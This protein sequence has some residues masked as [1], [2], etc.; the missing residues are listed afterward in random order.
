MF[1]GEGRSKYLLVSC[2]CPRNGFQNV[3]NHSPPPRGGNSR[4]QTMD[5]KPGHDHILGRTANCG[6]PSR[7]TY[8]M[9]WRPQT[10]LAKKRW[11]AR[12]GGQEKVR[13]REQGSFAGS[14]PVFGFQRYRI[15]KPEIGK[16]KG[17]QLFSRRL[18]LACCRLVNEC[19]TA[20]NS[21]PPATNPDRWC[22]APTAHFVTGERSSTWATPSPP[23]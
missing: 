7:S 20:T 10:V 21:S 18:P 17:T 13:S 22:S 1:A 9:Q 3:G 12:K 11:L 14:D 16:E 8:Q 19:Q 2:R 23:P 5:H 15:G 6:D 4:I